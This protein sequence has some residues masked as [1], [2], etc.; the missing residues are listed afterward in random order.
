MVQA[1]TPTFL[2][3]LP[4]DL[5]DITK[6]VFTITQGETKINKEGNDLGISGQVVSVY[7]TQEET[8]CFKKGT[9][10]L[11]LNWLYPNGERGC[12]N[13][14]TIEVTPNLLLEVLE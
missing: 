3:T 1:T 5:T 9:A 6:M 4:I 11:Q 7:L 2:L 8:M 12:S 14:V 13:I 10:R